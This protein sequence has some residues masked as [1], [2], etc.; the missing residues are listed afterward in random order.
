VGKSRTGYFASRSV[1][2]YGS[3][4]Q[5]SGFC[6]KKLKTLVAAPCRIDRHR[7]IAHETE[8]VPL[9]SRSR[10]H[11]PGRNPSP[12]GACSARSRPDAT[13]FCGRGAKRPCA[14]HKRTATDRAR[15]WPTAPDPSAQSSPDSVRTIVFMAALATRFG[16]V[17]RHRLTLQEFLGV[18][19]LQRRCKD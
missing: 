7:K 14:R 16:R 11:A 9:M 3:L 12:S 6:V 15:S 2:A 4:D 13:T 17:H 8:P 10:A 18:G 19:D 5:G 1:D